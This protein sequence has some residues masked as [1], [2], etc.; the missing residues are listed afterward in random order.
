MASESFKYI[1]FIALILVI[2]SSLLAFAANADF[3]LQNI[4]WFVLIAAFFY[5]TWRWDVVITLKEY[6]RA[7]IYRFGKVN[8][9]GGP[10]WAFIVPPLE[11]FDL[12]DLRVQT[13]DIPKQDVI[14]KD[15]I[16]LKVDAVIYLRVMKDPQSV[17]NVV[18]EVQDYRHAVKDYVISSLRD[19]VG[20]MNLASVIANIDEINNELTRLLEKISK[21]W[22]ISVDG[23]Q[24]KDV[25]IPR[26]VIDAM[27]E[28]KA[29][30]QEKLARIEK[31]YA[32]KAEID[33]VKEAS[34]DMSDKAL[35]Y[36]YLKALEELSKGKS[37]KLVFPMEFSRLAESISGNL[38]SSLLP[39]NSTANKYKGLLEQ[40]VNKAVGKAKKKEGKKTIELEED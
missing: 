16:E 12:V 23:V 24:L 6:E 25:D 10:G 20:T 8:R 7:V 29:A 3:F 27:H 32:H 21:G 18:V 19:V 39:D 35:S 26:I 1:V 38:S 36:Y 33:A 5:W 11:N 4:V 14:T 13:I 34:A 17:K 31:A 22:G 28:E 30:V 40:Y 9:V 15:S 2:L 37:T